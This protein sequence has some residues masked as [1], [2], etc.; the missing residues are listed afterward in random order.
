[1]K[2]TKF[3]ALLLLGIFT[4]ASCGDDN[5]E[6]NGNGNH[7]Q[8]THSNV[9]DFE[10]TY[11]DQLIDEPQYGGKLLYSGNRYAWTDEWTGLSGGL[12]GDEQGQYTFDNGGAAVSCYKYISEDFKGHRSKEYQLEVPHTNFSTN[13]LVVHCNPNTKAEEADHVRL[14]FPKPTFIN[15]LYISPTTYSLGA[16][17]Y[18]IEGTCRALTKGSDYLAI[19][20]TAYNGNEIV[21]NGNNSWL[22]IIKNGQL[23]NN[24]DRWI[25]FPQIGYVTD[26][27]LWMEGSDTDENGILRTP[28]YFA[29][30]NIDCNIPTNH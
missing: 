18:G 11:W 3:L 15:R 2:K 23:Q 28:A 10:G 20:I 5:E 26:L 13:F 24:M 17:L 14:T 7:H 1:M 4:M 30:D 29:I 9:V 19:H 16:A 8:T 22:S 25:Q 27:I 21:L 6:N 12:K